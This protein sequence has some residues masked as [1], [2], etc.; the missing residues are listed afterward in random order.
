[1][2]KCPNCGNEDE[3]AVRYCTKCGTRLDIGGVEPSSARGGPWRCS[4]CGWQ[5]SSDLAR[6]GSCGASR[7]SGQPLPPPSRVKTST[8]GIWDGS[9][10]PDLRETPITTNR[11][12]IGGACI[13]GSGVLAIISG[14]YS[15]AYTRLPVGLEQFKG[16]V[17]TCSV[18]IMLL[19]VIAIAGGLFAL[20]RKN[21]VLSLVGAITGMLAASFYVG[22]ILGLAGIIL[23]AFSRDEFK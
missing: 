4:S 10:V 9:A 8:A 11:P 16:L 21:F 12:V 5:N 7:D 17:D 22:A 23:V 6:C 3:G 13:L 1:M 14:V 15:L 2:T 18:I 20:S 19:G